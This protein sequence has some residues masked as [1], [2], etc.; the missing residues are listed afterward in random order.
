MAICFFFT[1]VVGRYNQNF[2]QG[3]GHVAI[4]V[5]GGKIINAKYHENK[6]GSDGGAV[7]EGL[8][9]EF[10]KRKDIVVVKRIV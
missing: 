7:E 9:K 5:G 1:G 2:P 6:D 8:L 3:I 10:L 4:Y